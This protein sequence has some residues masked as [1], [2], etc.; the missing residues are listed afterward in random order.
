MD[1]SPETTR[2]DAKE[3]TARYV[4]TLVMA[5]SAT[6]DAGMSHTRTTHIRKRFIGF[7]R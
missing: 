2:P 7:P 5:E 1:F 4:T 3:L 6:A